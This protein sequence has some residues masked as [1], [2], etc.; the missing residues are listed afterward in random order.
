MD[1]I[2]KLISRYGEFLRFALV[3]GFNTVLDFGIYIGLTRIFSFWQKYY[4]G[5]NLISLIIAT[6]SSFLLNKHF[7][8]RNTSKE[9]GRQYV[10][11]WL[12][13]L[14]YIGIVQVILFIGIDLF[15]IH[16]VLT[17][18]IATVIGMFWNFFAHKYWSFRE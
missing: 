10:K 13:A 7:T 14:V 17:K 5:A 15:Q 2:K 16:D 6:T 4:L 8:F 1:F 3:G 12:V 9:V 11:F 18:V